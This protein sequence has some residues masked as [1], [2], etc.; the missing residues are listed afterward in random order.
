MSPGWIRDIKVRGK[1]VQLLDQDI[2]GYLHDGVE[3]VDISHTAHKYKKENKI[4]YTILSLGKSSI[5]KSMRIKKTVYRKN[6]KI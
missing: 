1:L 3:G 5:Q 4:I 2:E 6:Q